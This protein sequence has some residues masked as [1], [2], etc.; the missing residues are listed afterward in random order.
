MRKVLKWVGVVIGSLLGFVIL[1]AVGLLVY[2]QITFKRTLNR[3]VYPITADTSA[4]AVARGEYLV[5]KVV[6]CGDCHA[7][8]PLNPDFTGQV[9]TIKEGPIEGVFAVPN[10]TSDVETGLGAWTDAEI[11]RAIREGVDRDGVELLVMPSKNYHSLSDQDVAAIIGYL[12]T[13]APVRNE[14]P[15]FQLNAV[16]KVLVALGMLPKGTAEAIREPVVHSAAGTPEYGVYLT[17]I[18]SCRDCHG[19]EL[20]GGAIPGQATSNQR[21]PNITGSGVLGT[22]E[23]E[24]FLTAFHTGKKPDGRTMS[25]SMPW[26]VYGQM[27]D[28]DL[29]AIFQYLQSLDYSASAQAK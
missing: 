19:E 11:A 14:I 16:G 26:K 21:T 8:D 3:E 15:P 25:D 5:H 4:D 28:Q 24:D 7:A 23:G 12:R 1:A 27:A 22:W 17:S 2:S 10:L 9:E 6:A 29:L 13:L 20:T 18:A